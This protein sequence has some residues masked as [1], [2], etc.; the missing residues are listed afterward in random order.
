M[1]SQR[2]NA[3]MQGLKRTKLV[4]MYVYVEREWF[5]LCMRTDIADHLYNMTIVSFQPPLATSLK[6]QFCEKKKGVAS[7][8]NEFILSSLVFLNYLTR[9]FENRSFETFH[10]IATSI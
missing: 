2:M 5:L 6:I 3:N 8:N 4:R 7:K 1:D 10:R 9:C